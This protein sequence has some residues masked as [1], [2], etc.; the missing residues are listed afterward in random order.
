MFCAEQQE[1][2]RG[3]LD[4]RSGSPYGAEQRSK[5]QQEA[6]A[7]LA[8]LREAVE[9]GN[10]KKVRA[11][12][13][14]AAKI[15]PDSRDVQFFQ[16]IVALLQ[17]DNRTAETW[18]ENARLQSPNSLS[19]TNNLALALCEQKD[20]AKIR[21]ALKYAEMNVRLTRRAERPLPLTPGCCTRR[22][23]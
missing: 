9:S 10:I 21:R 8:G 19:V 22:V 12:V 4:R 11:L 15:A 13:A 5:A 6:L 14:E 3:E 20:K 7:R 17:K 2:L 18:F 23:A 1:K 16:G